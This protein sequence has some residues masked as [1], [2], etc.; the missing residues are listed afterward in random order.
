MTLLR[1]GPN[2]HQMR[3]IIYVDS[4]EGLLIK[5]ESARKT[6]KKLLTYDT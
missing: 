4:N 1:R 5:N 6:W 3:R 2:L